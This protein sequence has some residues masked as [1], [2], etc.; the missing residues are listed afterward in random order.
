MSR[1]RI[2]EA[3]RLRLAVIL[4]GAVVALVCAL[5]LSGALAPLENIAYDARFRLL[6]QPG[7]ADE[8]LASR[9]VVIVAID[10]A[11]FESPE[12]TENF[13]RWPWRRAFY[14]MVLQFLRAGGARLVAVDVTLAGRDPH[15]LPGDPPVPDD[16]ALGEQLERSGNVVLAFSLTESPGLAASA[17]DPAAAASRWE[18]RDDPAAAGA[19]RVYSGLDLPLRDLS[20]RAGRLGST[21]VRADADGVLRRAPLLFPYQPPGGGPLQ[22]YPAF[23]LAAMAGAEARARPSPERQRAGSGAEV[24]NEPGPPADARGSDTFPN[25]A[26]F[27]QGGAW[28]AGWVQLGSRRAPADAGGHVLLYWYGPRE[29]GYEY[30]FRHYPAWR[31]VNAAIALDS[32]ETPELSPA[33]FKDK[34]VLLGPTAVGIGDFHPSPFFAATPGIEYQATLLSNLLQGH[35]VRPA[36]GAWALLAIALLGA[37]T[38][39]AV[40]RFADW[41]A[42]SAVTALLAAAYLAADLALFRAA[43]LS[44]AQ[45]APLACVALSYTAGNLGRYLTEGREKRRYRQTLVKYVAPQLVDAIMANPRMAGLHNEKLVL[46][47]L[48]SDVR[49]FTSISEKMPVEQLVGTLNELLN[50][51]VEVIFRNGGTLDKFVGDCVMAIWGA[52]VRQD[53]HAELAARSALEMQA[54]L[55]ALNQRWRAEGR[56]EMHIGVG[57]NTG[58][59]VFGNIGSERRMDFTVIGDSVNLAARLESATKDL[60]ASIVISQATYER[61]AHLADVRDLGTIHVKGKDVPIRVYELLGMSGKEQQSHAQAHASR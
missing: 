21:T 17:D 11:S 36:G 33:E 9:D 52:P 44:L 26:R 61:I 27:T 46:T 39:F 25:A 48:F 10:N 38:T 20:A 12:M 23:A 15:L 55:D 30:S 13:G 14:A 4:G 41:R 3:H 40:W 43:R 22:H 1:F 34:I 32:G 56:P 6:A 45:V 47:V 58:E 54:A 59:M 18:V 37:G 29:P 8:I 42:Y 60:K 5:H 7:F 19:G 16:A 2:D 31:V 28:R 24:R 50:A 49:G 53:N 35:F 51:L 57:V